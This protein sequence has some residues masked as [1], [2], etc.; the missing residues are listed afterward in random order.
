[1]TTERK[2][3]LC[4]FFRFGKCRHLNDCKFTHVDCREG[5][6]C[7]IKECAFGHVSRNEFNTEKPAQSFSVSVDDGQSQ[8]ISTQLNSVTKTDSGIPQEAP[9]KICRERRKHTSKEK[10]DRKKRKIQSW[11]SIAQ[12]RT[13]STHSRETDGDTSSSSNF[14]RSFKKSKAQLLEKIDR[15]T[16]AQ[17]VFAL[18]ADSNSCSTSA[19]SVSV[20]EADGNSCSTSAQ[21]FTVSV[22]DGKSQQILTQLTSVIKADS[23]IPQQAPSKIRRER[24]KHTS[25]EKRDRKK[26]KIQSWKSIAQGRTQPD[27]THFRETDGDTSSSSHFE[28]SSKKSIGFFI[29]G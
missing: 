6:K 12:D 4:K 26:R 7:K 23:G 15:S 11:K 25:K 20:S 10:H 21:S 5:E 3:P 14:E 19:Q 22:D 17:S 2:L 1:M 13:Q 18:E 27:V 16:S 9:S 24:R 8:Q 28:R 29:G